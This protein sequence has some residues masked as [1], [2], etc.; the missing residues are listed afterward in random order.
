MNTKNQLSNSLNMLRQSPRICGENKE[1]ISLYHKENI[2]RGIS[3]KRCVKVL[4]ELRFLAAQSNKSFKEMNKQDVIALLSWLE[5]TPYSERTKRDYKIVLRSFFKW[6][7]Q[8]N[9][10]PEE[11]AWIKT[12]L[13]NSHKLPEELLTEE[14]I[15][16]LVSA[17]KHPRDRAFILTLYE[18][19]CRIGELLSLEVRNVSFD[20]Y[21]AVLR[22]TG[23]TGDRRVRVISSAPA[24]ALW[25]DHHPTGKG[26]LFCS[27]D[28][29]ALNY[30][31]IRC[32]LLSLAKKAGIKKKVNPHLFRHSRA[33]SLANK[34]TE[35]QMK[36]Y[37]G[38]TQSSEM[39]SVYVHL[40]GRDV[41]KALLNI[42]GLEQSK[43]AEKEQFV[44]RHCPRCKEANSPA[45]KYC[46]RCGSA[47]DLQTALETEDR[48]NEADELM[49]RLVA[50]PEVRQF[51]VERMGGLNK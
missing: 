38:W 45:S 21:G 30:N 16:A 34:L 23:K 25:L 31:T 24:I 50:D 22:V 46:S 10:Y 40:S 5:S 20:D 3:P 35:A 42:Y 11:V 39:A 2:A 49:N 13:R 47:L 37:F 19:G 28:G 7:R 32:R 29:R 44:P 17:A 26:A 15:G 6:L 14:D 9:H 4:Q 8:T 36:E 41:D 43:E 18:S 27:S 1:A 33:T 12:P 51:L 48:R